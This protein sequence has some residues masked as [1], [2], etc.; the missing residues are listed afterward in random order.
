MSKLRMGGTRAGT[1]PYPLQGSTAWRALAACP[2]GGERGGRH[3]PEGELLCLLKAVLEQDSHAK[4]QACCALLSSAGSSPAE[5][6]GL[7]GAPGG[8]GEQVGAGGGG[9]QQGVVKLRPGPLGAAPAGRDSTGGAAGAAQSR[10][11][12][13]MAGNPP[14]G[15]GVGVAGLVPP[16]VPRALPPMWHLT[17]TPCSG[18]GPHPVPA[19]AW[20]LRCRAEAGAPA[21]PQGRV[22]WR[23]S[24]WAALGQGGS[25][26]R[27]PAHGRCPGQTHGCTGI[28]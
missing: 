25:G 10:Q 28:E 4:Q 24:W 12:M 15:C 2:A 20:R 17:S 11:G 9:E 26:V 16:S 6:A 8:G 14:R 13:T 23:A 19:P 3:G 21:A 7:G 22:S 1:A 18:T 27:A 5:L